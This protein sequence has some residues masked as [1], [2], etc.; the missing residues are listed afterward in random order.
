MNIRVAGAVLA[1]AISAASVSPAGAGVYGDELSKCLVES[2]GA[3]DR[4]TFVVWMFSAM[5]YHPDVAGYSTLTDAQ[6]TA[7]AGDAGGLMQR[8]LVKDCRQ[9]SVKA[10][11]YEGASA[12]PDAF[13]L[14]GEVAMQGLTSH[15]AVSAGLEELGQGIDQKQFD[16]LA[17]EAGASA[18]K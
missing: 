4:A 3:K 10:L 16:D 15:P 2:A 5:S 12:L 6:R 9:Q 7:M 11:K 14:F 18:S 17:K 1:L 13:R 8:L